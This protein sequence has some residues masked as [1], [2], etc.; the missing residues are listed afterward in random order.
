MEHSAVSVPQLVRTSPPHKRN[1]AGGALRLQA[2]MYHSLGNILSFRFCA[3]GGRASGISV[4]CIT[5]SL[6]SKASE[7]V[8]LADT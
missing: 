2:V 1:V 6:L 3:A 5:E 4:P 8:V 7:T